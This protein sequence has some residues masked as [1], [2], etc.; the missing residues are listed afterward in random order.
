[1]LI[2][3][4]VSSQTS[5]YGE[6][7]AAYIYNFAKYTTWPQKLDTF[8]IAILGNTSIMNDLK[9]ILKGKKILTYEIVLQQIKSIEEIKDFQMVYLPSSSS[10]DLEPLLKAGSNKNILIVTEDDL[11]KQGACISFFIED[12]RLKFKIN[13][14][15][16]QKFGLKAADGLLKLGVL[17]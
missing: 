2:I 16:L 3:N 8:K 17:L 14:S 6:L 9:K 4:E 1:M 7:Q 11:A 15:M 13:R 5:S 12:E 10:K